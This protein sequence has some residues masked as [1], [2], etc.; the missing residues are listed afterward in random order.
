MQ[1]CLIKKT[2]FSCL[3]SF[4]KSE[5][6]VYEVTL[7]LGHKGSIDPESGMCASLPE[8]EKQLLDLKHLLHGQNLNQILSEESMNLEKLF[9]FCQ[10]KSASDFL[11]ITLRSQSG[12]E[13]KKV[14]LQD[15][16][17]SYGLIQDWP[18][19]TTQGGL[20]TALEIEKAS[21]WS[22]SDQQML[23]KHLSAVKNEKY[24]GKDQQV[25][26][27]TFQKLSSILELQPNIQ[28]LTL[29]SKS[30]TLSLQKVRP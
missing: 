20:M 23:Q 22:Q 1:A 5:A 19:L 4:E 16:Q 29:N 27:S 6:Q 24:Q 9:W 7:E 11:Q 15:G 17:I 28:F 18:I 30:P 13:S 2:G 12:S 8:V 14:K 3:A 10:K 26:I 25:V 21:P